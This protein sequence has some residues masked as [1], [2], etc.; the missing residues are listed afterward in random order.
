MFDDLVA[1]R[2]S[3]SRTWYLTAL[4]VITHANEIGTRVV[5]GA[6]AQ[7]TAKER[8]RAASEASRNDGGCDAGT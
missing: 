6:L 3:P 4:I 8:A 1:Y 5:P 7:R 2:G